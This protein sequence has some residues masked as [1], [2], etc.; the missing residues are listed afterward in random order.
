MIANM[1]LNYGKV[2][3]PPLVRRLLKILR[4]TLAKAHN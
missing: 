4:P 3:A 2:T 1:G